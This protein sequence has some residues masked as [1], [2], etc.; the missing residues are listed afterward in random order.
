MQKYTYS[1]SFQLKLYKRSLILSLTI[2][3]LQDAV[4]N[5]CFRLDFMVLNWN[6]AQ[7][8]YKKL[9]ASDITLEEKWH[10]YRFSGESLKK[11]ASE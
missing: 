8:F 4:E 11:L 10:T 3:S 5:N 1:L 9:D 7:D 2:N 6:S